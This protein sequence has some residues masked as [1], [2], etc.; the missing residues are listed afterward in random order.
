[1][2]MSPTH[3]LMLIVGFALGSAVGGVARKPSKA[4]V[5]HDL[6]LIRDGER[7]DA[8]AAFDRQ[9]DK[10][11]VEHNNNA[12]FTEQGAKAMGCAWAS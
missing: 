12:I 1:M 2:R 5:C 7:A 11:G 3:L 10:A 4:Q 6:K 8:K 9:D